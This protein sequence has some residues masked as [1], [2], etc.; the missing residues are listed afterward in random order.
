MYLAKLRV[1][2]AS[3][4]RVHK[5]TIYRDFIKQIIILSAIESNKSPLQ[6]HHDSRSMQGSQKIIEAA[7]CV[8]HAHKD[9]II[10]EVL[11]TV[12]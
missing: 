11:S 10:V 7:Q 6:C 3:L 8:R 9:Y 5:T 2:M 12:R 1:S 4:P